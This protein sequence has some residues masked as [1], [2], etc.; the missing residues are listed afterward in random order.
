MTPERLLDPRTAPSAAPTRDRAFRARAVLGVAI[1]VWCVFASVFGVQ[2]Y[3]PPNRSIA[4]PIVN[5]MV[6]AA[7]DALWLA[8]LGFALIAARCAKPPGARPWGRGYIVLCAGALL[9]L[10]VQI[11]G[12]TCAGGCESSVFP[13]VKNVLLYV[14]GGV[15]LGY[16]AANLRLER[17]ALAAVLAG[18]VA[19]IV[20][21]IAVFAFF[22]FHFKLPAW[23]NDPSQPLLRMYGTM[24]NPN[25]VGWAAVIALPIILLGSRAGLDDGPLQTAASIAAFIAI[26]CS[27]SF[28][29][30]AGA[31]VAV[32]IFALLEWR[33]GGSPWRPMRRATA[34]ALIGF[35]AALLLARLATPGYTLELVLRVVKMFTTS[36]ES[37]DVRAHDLAET[38]THLSSPLAMLLGLSVHGEPFRQH[39]SIML[40]LFRNFGT[41]GLSLFMLPWLYA[42][43]LSWRM[44]RARPGDT[45]TLAFAPT[46]VAIVAVNAP[47]QPQ[48][49]LFPVD[50][51]AAFLLG[52]WAATSARELAAPR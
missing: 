22:E 48:L 21:S 35:V 39:D 34:A 37:V 1:A 26:F 5:A 11:T 12:S 45:L 44:A 10:A 40:T 17:E 20:A 49:Q 15:V 41:I 47:L 30:L 46:L 8:L 13:L 33:G 31:A 16:L 29:A 6:P 28:S 18:L 25:S 7:K 27:A 42:L 14:L 4:D 43:R 50:F 32:G 36:P 9:A 24:G 23:L 2:L 38:W 51:F 52:L 3:L 19:A